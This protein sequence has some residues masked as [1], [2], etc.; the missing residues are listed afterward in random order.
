MAAVIERD[1]SQR[2]AHTQIRA[3]ADP[4]TRLGRVAALYQDDAISVPATRL[5]GP[6]A[7]GR[8]DAVAEQGLPR[9]TDQ[10]AWD[11][12]RGHLATLAVT[13]ADPV[14]ALHEAIG[15]R[16]LGSALD[17]AAVLDWRLDPTGAHFAGVGPLPWL[18][19]IPLRPGR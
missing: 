14:A 8:I 15:S 16:E 18:P 10:P 9:L 19:S 3:D 7:M 4:A 17:P 13:G 6:Q 12:L 11:T 1:G 2:F 5:A